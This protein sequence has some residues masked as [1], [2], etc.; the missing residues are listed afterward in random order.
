[1]KVLVIIQHTVEQATAYLESVNL[2][3]LPIFTRPTV[4]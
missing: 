3:D 4:Q 2:S 1:M